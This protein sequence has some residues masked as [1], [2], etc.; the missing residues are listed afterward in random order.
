METTVLKANKLPELTWNHFNVNHKKL[1]LTNKPDC[2][3]ADMLIDNASIEVKNSTS[4]DKINFTAADDDTNAYIIN[5]ASIKKSLTIK[6][7]NSVDEPLVISF[8]INP[9]AKLTC[10]FDI[11]LEENSSAN[12]V[13]AVSSAA[14]STVQYS[15]LIRVHAKANSSLKLTCL[16]LLGKGATAFNNVL[17][18]IE[19]NAKANILQIPLGGRTAL[20]SAA[21][22][23][24]GYKASS[25]IRSDY[26]GHLDQRIDLNYITRHY[27]KKTL[28]EIKMTGL[29][30]GTSRKTARGTLDFHRGC[31]GASGN[32]NENVLLLSKDA[33]NKSVPLILCD[34]DDVAG[35]HGAAI[36]TLDDERFFYLQ[37]RGIDKETAY[38]L[39][40][41]SAVERLKNLVPEVLANKIDDYNKEVLCH[42]SV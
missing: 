5:N 14:Q 30:S 36:G 19:D 3:A 29:L 1:E 23:L 6:K 26:I 8:N 34:E 25:E 4:L 16:Q 33:K 7:G 28:S 27:G 20:A 17:A 15:D 35:N 18:R 2:A 37:A 40:R 31:K 11:V 38:E 12:I 21:T 10:L 42:E 9:A 13:V 24:C 39:F 22:D 32:E 41:N